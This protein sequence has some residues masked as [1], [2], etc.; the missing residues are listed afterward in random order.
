MIQIENVSR[1]GFLKGIVGT[2]AF[3]LTARLM[4]AALLEA[5]DTPNATAMSKAVLQP[6]VYLAIDTDGTVFIVAHRAEMGSGN[7]T[8]LPIIVADELDADWN[9]VKVVE[10]TG[11][12]KYGDQDT[13]GSHSVRSFFDPLREAGA[14]ARWMLI[15]S[16]A[17]TWNVPVS[18]CTT[19]LHTVVH[20]PSGKKLGY[21]ELAATAATLPVPKK[22]DLKLKSRDEWRYIG[23]PTKGYDLRAM[24]TG[25]AIYGQDT[26]M[27]GMLYASIAHPPVFGS[28]VQSLD[29]SEARKVPGVKQTAKLPA[30]KPPV[31]YQPLGG[32]AVIADNTWAAF[33]GKKKLKVQWTKSDHAVWNSEAYRK[34]LEETARKP[35]K[36]VRENGNVDEVFAKGGGKIV[37]AGTT[38]RCWRTQRWS[39]RQRWRTIRMAR[40]RCGPRRKIHR[41]RRKRWLRRWAAKKK[42]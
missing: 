40:S 4:P 28:Q 21:G 30:F 3:V 24:S 42:T 33:Q 5:M 10:A 41:V 2:G 15:E 34:E 22:E 9:R 27:E 14:S 16:A 38:R 18:E 39:H 7:R 20:K 11:N 23:K 26:H 8:G 37:E 36:V 32:V 19:D 13:D 29:D 6:N 25:K 17:K 35:G 31:L 12:E 1:R